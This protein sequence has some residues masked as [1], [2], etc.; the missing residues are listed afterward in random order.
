MSS[1]VDR[2]LH[3]PSWTEVILGAVLS[4]LLGIVLG[5]VLMI[6]KPVVV[7]KELPKE[8]VAGTIYYVEGVRGDANKARQILAKRKALIE[9]QTVKVT[10]DEVNALVSAVAAPTPAAKPDDKAGTPPPA[11]KSNETVAAG[12]PNVRVRKGVMQVGVPLTLNVFGFEQRLIAQA[13]GGFT[14]DGDVF[15][16]DPSEIYLGSCP[17]QRLPFLSSYIRHKVTASQSVPEDI[18]TAWRKLANVTIED[19]TIVLA[20]Q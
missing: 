5:A 19:N 1:K 4:L 12:T 20:A 6:L 17:V 9:G 2:T 11:P 18:V 8:P 7:A 16:Y 3:G 10:E 14:K 13:R 15:V